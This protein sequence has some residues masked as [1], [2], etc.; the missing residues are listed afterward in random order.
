MGIGNRPPELSPERRSVRCSARFR[1]PRRSAVP[2]TGRDH[3]ADVGR[4]DAARAW[5]RLES[6]ARSSSRCSSAPWRSPGSSCPDESAAR[7][8]RDLGVPMKRGSRSIRRQSR[9]ASSS[10]KEWDAWRRRAGKDEELDENVQ[11]SAPLIRRRSTFMHRETST[12][13]KRRCRALRA[14]IYNRGIRDTWQA[15]VKMYRGLARPYRSAPDPRRR[16]QLEHLQTSA[17][18]ARACAGASRSG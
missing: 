13:P 11:L 18:C 7:R 9:L 6:G 16:R 14:W 2:T 8:Q 4:C 1:T 17:I 15:V 3:R 12:Y 10:A 5:R